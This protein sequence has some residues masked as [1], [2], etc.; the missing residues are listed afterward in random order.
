MR[1]LLEIYAHTRWEVRICELQFKA[2]CGVLRV[3]SS[4][5]LSACV[6]Y[7]TY[8]CSRLELSRYADGSARAGSPVV[9]AVVFFFDKD[10]MRT[11]AFAVSRLR[12]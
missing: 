6:K 1:Y 4:I 5:Y 12:L 8:M 2:A 11:I 7:G 10:S 3:C 9:E